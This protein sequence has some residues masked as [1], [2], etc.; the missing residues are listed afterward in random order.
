M[1]CNC[2]LIFLVYIC[3]KNKIG[4]SK[5]ITSRYRRTEILYYRHMKFIFK[6]TLMHNTRGNSISF[7][8]DLFLSDFVCGKPE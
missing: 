2:W 6:M 3:L 7:R 5:L 4:R 1:K 8:N